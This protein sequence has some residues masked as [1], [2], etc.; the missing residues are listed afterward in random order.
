MSKNA[1]IALKEIAIVAAKSNDLY[2]MS[3]R[4]PAKDGDEAREIRDEL[5]RYGCISR[6][7]VF[8]RY[9][10]RCQLENAAFDYLNE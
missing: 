1:R 5:V 8:G 2:V 4:L 9:Y 3:V 7:E 10:I 6:A